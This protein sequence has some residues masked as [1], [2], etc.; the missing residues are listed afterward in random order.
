LDT[1]TVEKRPAAEG[2]SIGVGRRAGLADKVAE[3][4]NAAFMRQ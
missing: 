3:V 4:S 2:V 1:Y